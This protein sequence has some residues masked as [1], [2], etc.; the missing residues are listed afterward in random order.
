VDDAYTLVP[1]GAVK[2]GAAGVYRVVTA[3][4][5]VNP[6]PTTVTI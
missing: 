4:E 6:D 5:T 1:A 2:I 3:A